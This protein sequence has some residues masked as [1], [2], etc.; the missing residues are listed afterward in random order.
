MGIVDA[1]LDWIV[2]REFEHKTE[3]EREQQLLKTE[4]RATG[5]LKG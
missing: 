1:G 2:L 5:L 4:G 3:S